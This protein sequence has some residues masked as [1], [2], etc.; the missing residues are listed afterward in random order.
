VTDLKADLE[1]HKQ[2]GY[3]EVLAGALAAKQ[4]YTAIADKF[5]SMPT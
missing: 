1:R 2:G 5:D 4:R 3:K